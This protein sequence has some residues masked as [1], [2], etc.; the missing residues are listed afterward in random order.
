LSPAEANELTRKLAKLEKLP[1]DERMAGIDE[2]A[3][4]NLD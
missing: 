1:L 4:R 2:L 3:A